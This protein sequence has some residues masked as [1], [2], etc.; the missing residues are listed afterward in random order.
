MTDKQVLSLVELKRAQ[1]FQSVAELARWVEGHVREGG[2]LDWGKLNGIELPRGEAREYLMA[3]IERDAPGVFRRCLRNEKTEEFTSARQAA[4]AAGV[5]KDKQ[6]VEP[7][8][9]NVAESLMG[10]HS[11]GFCRQVAQELLRLAP[12]IRPKSVPTTP[13]RSVRTEADDAEAQSR[14]LQAEREAEKRRAA[15]EAAKAEE[16]AAE[17]QRRA[18]R[19]K[20]VR[21]QGEELKADQRRRAREKRERDEAREAYKA[22][23][24]EAQAMVKVLKLKVAASRERQGAFEREKRANRL[25]L[26]R[27]DTERLENQLAEQRASVAEIEARRL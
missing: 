24:A 14:Q 9:T 12:G 11:Q 8:P 4:I 5:I 15:A 10:L 19:S 1:R 16:V 20:A 6:P 13:S 3:R 25:A 7:T 23:L 2:H 17:R 26:Q 18:E 21:E 22:E 27:T